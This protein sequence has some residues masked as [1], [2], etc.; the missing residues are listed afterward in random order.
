M[1]KR[2]KLTADEYRIASLERLRA[3]EAL[4]SEG[5]HGAAV[6][7]YGTAIECIFR[8]YWMKFG[9]NKNLESAHNLRNLYHDGFV[10]I[11]PK[12]RYREVGASLSSAESLWFNLLRYWN[13]DKYSNYLRRIEWLRRHKGD[14]LTNA[15][16]IAK[17]SAHTLVA[18]GDTKWDKT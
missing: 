17:N 15:A 12:R 7:V 16:R 8:A 11:V 4:H 13:E 14:P 10:N 6:W 9:E 3:A 18:L 1:A 5:M 2:S